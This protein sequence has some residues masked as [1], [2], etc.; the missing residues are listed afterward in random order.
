MNFH[1]IGVA[2][3]VAWIAY[4]S[5]QMFLRVAKPK[6]SNAAS[7]YRQRSNA[8]SDLNHHD[9]FEDKGVHLP[10]APAVTML[11]PTT[12]FSI[13]EGTLIDAGGNL[14]NQDINS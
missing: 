3:L 14:Y 12:G 13:E 10:A 6:R 5:V 7:T 2:L 9:L 11:N 8:Y 4:R 1:I